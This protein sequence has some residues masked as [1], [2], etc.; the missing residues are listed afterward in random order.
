MNDSQPR[1]LF[2]KSYHAIHLVR[3]SDYRRVTPYSPMLD[4]FD[5]TP[6]TNKINGTLYPSRDGGSIARH[7]PN[8]ADD[9]IWEEWELTR[10]Y[11]VTRSELI[12]MGTDPSTVSKL[13]DSLWGLDDDP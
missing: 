11:P 8:P 2:T 10:V 9:A 5:F 7:Q 3:N 12:K 6:T 4:R 1:S 13:E